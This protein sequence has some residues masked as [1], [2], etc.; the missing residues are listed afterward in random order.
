MRFYLGDKVRK[1]L[2]ATV[3]EFLIMKSFIYLL[4][5][6]AALNFVAYGQRFMNYVSL[7]PLPYIHIV[8]AQIIYRRK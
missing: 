7:E 3:K 8:V 4:S 6:R 1:R 2:I 5:L